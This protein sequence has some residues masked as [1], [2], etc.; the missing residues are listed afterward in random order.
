M[1]PYDHAI[2]L[3]FFLRSPITLNMG[4]CGGDYPLENTDDLDKCKQVARDL[5][6]WYW[7]NCSGYFRTLG[8]NAQLK[9]RVLHS[10]RLQIFVKKE[11]RLSPCCKDISLF[12]FFEMGSK[13]FSVHLC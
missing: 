2:N 11:R 3:S 9:I 6:T 10:C 5:C 13:G 4:I 7:D 8:Y 12:S 1:I